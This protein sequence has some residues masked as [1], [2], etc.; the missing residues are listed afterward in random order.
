M[1]G[2]KHVANWLIG[3]VL[4]ESCDIQAMKTYAKQIGAD[5]ELYRQALDKVTRMPKKK[6]RPNRS[7]ALCYC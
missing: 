6:I 3:Q 5:E 4:D 7:N 2:D 1:A